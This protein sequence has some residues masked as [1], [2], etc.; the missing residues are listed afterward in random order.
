MIKLKPLLPLLCGHTQRYSTI[1]FYYVVSALL[2]GYVYRIF[3]TGPEHIL[4][5][6]VAI[7]SI[8]MSVL[9]FVL[10]TLSLYYRLRGIK[11]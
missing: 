11:V 10:S 1:I 9:S 3:S 5:L 6:I 8:V 4:I 7:V 2:A